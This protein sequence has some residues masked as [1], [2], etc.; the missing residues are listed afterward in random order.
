MIFDGNFKTLGNWKSW[1]KNGISRIYVSDD[2]AYLE[3]GDSG[4]CNLVG[5]LS[6]EQV[7]YVYK[8]IE[9]IEFKTLFANL[10]S[11]KDNAKAKKAV[12]KTI[13]ARFG[14]GSRPFSAEEVN[15][16]MAEIK[17]AQAELDA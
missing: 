7:S 12:E 16:M 1:S 10:K 6:K 11:N 13:K 5:N 8:H 3:E 14:F 4:L 15:A 17:A 9:K 2:G